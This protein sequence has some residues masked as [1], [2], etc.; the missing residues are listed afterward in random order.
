MKKDVSPP[1]VKQE[2]CKLKTV[3][4]NG[5]DRIPARLLKDAAP[6][7]VKP[8]AY[9]LNLTNLTGIVPQE[10]KEAKETPIFKSG[11]KD[12]I[13]NYRPISVLP[14]IS[15]IMERAGQAQLVSFLT[16]NNALSEH[17]ASGNYTLHKLLLRNLQTSSQ[18]T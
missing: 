3:K 5:L 4:A 13:N 17:Q 9:L 18:S 6:G 16:E 10:W 2:L 14:L 11:E 12:D 7:I 8:I 1:F 15:K